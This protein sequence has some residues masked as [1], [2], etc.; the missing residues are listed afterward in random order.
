MVE[1]TRFLVFKSRIKV[2]F[3]FFPEL[4]LR[5]GASQRLR[6]SGPR[7]ASSCRGCPHRR[8]AFAVRC[9][10]LTP[11]AAEGRLCEGS[12]ETHGRA[13]QVLPESSAKARVPP[14]VVV[15]FLFVP[16]DWVTKGAVKEMWRRT[17]FPPGSCDPPTLRSVPRSPAQSSAQPRAFATSPGQPHP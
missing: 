8:R 5:L 2:D 11:A 3:K 9:R 15:G 13:F 16:K 6:Q 7:K 4:L 10:D 1:E 12:P 17:L 14:F